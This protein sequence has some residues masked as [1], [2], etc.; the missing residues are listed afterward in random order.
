MNSGF[1]TWAVRRAL[2]NRS[3]LKGSVESVS[4]NPDEVRIQGLRLERNGAQ[5]TIPSLEADLPV[6]PAAFWHR[7]AVQKFVA[8]GWI[9]DL[10]NASP[11]GAARS[12]A[13]ALIP[14]E[15]VRGPAAR[16]N[17]I[18]PSAR[19]APAGP[20]PEAGEAARAFQGIF[21]NLMLPFDLS[22]NDVELE[23]D[24]IVRH[25]GTGAPSPLTVHLVFSGGGLAVGREGRFTFNVTAAPAATAD[26]L[27]NAM[28]VNGTLGASMDTPRSFMRAAAHIHA[29]ASG[30]KLPDGVRL[31]VDFVASGGPFGE[32]YSLAFTGQTKELATIA[33]DFSRAR[34]RVS[35]LWKL[36]VR[37]DDLAPFAFGRPLPLFDLVGSGRFETDA[38]LVQAQLSGSLNATADRLAAVGSEFSA[39]GAVKLTADFDVTRRGALYR[40]DHLRAS[41]SGAHPV[42]T[43][44]G[45]Q[46]FAFNAGTGELQV[47]DTAR[48]LVGVTLQG[49]PLEWAQ[50]F[51]PGVELTGSPLRGELVAVAGKGGL[52]VRTG[53]PL[54][55][56]GLSIARNGRPVARDVDL[57]L[58]L[59]AD[60]T[61]Q[62]WQL[63]LSR[64]AA[65][66]PA[67]GG[68]GAASEPD[69]KSSLFSIT[70]KCGRLA[71]PNQPIE[72]TGRLDAG[73]PTLLAQPEIASI[74]RP[75]ADSALASGQ[76]ACDFSANL[77]AKRLVE[78][79][80][81]ISNLALG[82]PVDPQVSNLGP[83]PEELMS[84]ADITS[85][86]RIEFG[87]NGRATVTLPLLIQKGGR[88][89]DAT[90]RGTVFL[91][92]KTVVIDGEVESGS[93]A[94]DEIEPFVAAFGT[95]DTAPAAPLADA[96]AAVGAG[97]AP[98]PDA[99]PPWAGFGG[100]LKFALARVAR[101]NSV[102]SKVSGTV[103]A[104]A[105]SLQVDDLH[106]GFADGGNA[107]INGVLAFALAAARPYSLRA[108]LAAENLNPA[109]VFLALNPA[110]PPTI[111]GNFD[112]AAHFL[113]DGSNLADLADRIR[114]D[115]QAT[116]K[117]GTF[118]VLSPGAAPKAESLGKI[119]AA[120]EYLGGVTSAIT[121]RKDS[122]DLSNL[123]EAVTSLV[124]SFRTI[125][126]D[127]LSVS[128]SRDGSLDTVLRDFALISPE[129]RMAG[130]GRLSYQEGATILTQPLAMDFKLRARGHEA[131]LLKKVGALD[132]KKPDDL[133]YLACTLPI[134]IAG[135]LA[136][137]DHG[138]FDAAL[139]KLAIE[140]SGA[141]DLLDKLLG[142]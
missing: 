64:C 80:I 29:A 62:G 61:P 13:A 98:A 16:G 46:A 139:A 26:E 30:P 133:G 115:C 48:D 40:V 35:G 66:G 91:Q 103:R 114:G 22:V 118:R 21:A 34:G 94:V 65:M 90:L 141:G 27:V 125:H 109:P 15:P 25:P 57:Q 136:K 134:H 83:G 132:P 14:T 8:K 102:F 52:A 60:Y 106:I 71:G 81:A 42:L 124:D 108:D 33:A 68:P 4:A 72:L 138:Q 49:V 19:A 128:L 1:Q 12:I 41:L 76:L 73:L 37:D 104:E 129:I 59:D 117:G 32:S 39:I 23:G 97:D 135:T 110:E 10:T 58:E 63:E 122:G 116:S 51:L 93:I 120:I 99:A 67:R 31:S 47:A 36:D 131:D 50:P 126:Y 74:L 82:R 2:S 142:R 111:D 100:R 137:P 44:E 38:S 70:A 85:D 11:G 75:G 87:A 56:A 6:L 130:E 123:A 28:T 107:R 3:I 121:G 55:F 113:G 78:L 53:A 18:V 69:L 17:G 45:L 119:S 112:L 77:A 5:L 140:R 86:A 96:Q 95:G 88:K 105:S 9:L 54:E 43:I 84:L 92:G 20:T 7:V 101:A 89:S 127:Q 79:K 24:V